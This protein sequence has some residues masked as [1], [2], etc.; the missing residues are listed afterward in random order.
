MTIEPQVEYS[1]RP[2][3]GDRLFDQMSPHIF[4]VEVETPDGE[5][6]T[7]TAF[8]IARMPQANKLILATAKHVVEVPDKGTTWWTLTQYD[9]NAKP[10]RMVRFGS[11]KEQFGKVPFDKHKHID[12]G[13]LTTPT[14]DCAGKP[15]SPKDESPPMLLNVWE[16]WSTGTRVAWAGFPA[17]VE[18]SLGFPQLC[19]FEGCISAMVDTSTKQLY[20]VDGHGMPGISGGPVFS[21]D[22]TTDQLVVIGVVSEYRFAGGALPGFCVFEPINQLAALVREWVTREPDRFHIRFR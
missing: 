10:T 5:K 17:A 9:C 16:G 21:H 20:I 7:G 13:Y 4:R 8:T 15:F 19:Y 11:D 22:A 3:C 1:S 18:S 14:V 2:F 12:I 6:W